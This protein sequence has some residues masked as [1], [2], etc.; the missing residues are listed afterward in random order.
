MTTTNWSGFV[1]V[2]AFFALILSALLLPLRSY[3]K[4]TTNYLEVLDNL[5]VSQ[6]EKPSLL[7]TKLTI[8]KLI[9]ADLDV[10]LTRSRIESMVEDIN[11]MTTPAM[12]GWQRLDVLR[13]YIYEAG[14]WNNETVFSYD[15]DDPQGISRKSR[16]IHNYLKTRKGN[17]VSM[18]VL[19]AIL[20]QEIGLDMTLSTAPL[21]VFVKYKD[22]SGKTINIE[23]TSGGHP[24]RAE[25]YQ[26]NLPMLPKAIKNGMFMDELTPE[27]TIAVL[28]H[29]LASHLLRTEDYENAILVSDRLIPLFP[30]YAPLYM[31]RGSGYYKLIERD[32][33][34]KYPDVNDIPKELQRQFRSF[35]YQNS[36]S[37]QKADE[38]GW[39]DPDELLAKRNAEK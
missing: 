11:T 3:A 28:G 23:A 18:P 8:D 10:A 4:S 17:C 35:M 33:Q 37:F 9:D 2:L 19:H 26:K 15:L 39:A 6:K 34:K 14:D 13:T 12:S 32:F 31:S 36:I 29:D 21:H 25:W 7:D 22:E 1:K 24:A 16:L 5:V 20:G 30:N 27:Q 38:L